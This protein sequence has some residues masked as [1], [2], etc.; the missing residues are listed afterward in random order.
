[1][2]EISDDWFAATN[3]CDDIVAEKQTLW[4]I[5]H[6]YILIHSCFSQAPSSLRLSLI[7]IRGE[8]WNT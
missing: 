2:P 4:F 1:M 5:V 8:K 3:I 6:V 7:K